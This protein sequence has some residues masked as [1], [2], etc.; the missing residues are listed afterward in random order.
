MHLVFVNQINF[1]IINEHP[2]TAAAGVAICDCL[3][4]MGPKHRKNAKCLDI[5]NT[6]K[7]SSV[8]N[9][10]T[11]VNIELVLGLHSVNG[12]V[13]VAFS[14]FEDK[15]DITFDSLIVF[16]TMELLAMKMP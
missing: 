5:I 3:S 11:K 7:L 15:L 10:G 9:R 2:S 8:G 4:H 16:P 6:Y 12:K 14:Q 1:D 13:M